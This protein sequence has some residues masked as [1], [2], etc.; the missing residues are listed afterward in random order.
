MDSCDRTTMPSHLG[1]D[2]DVVNRTVPN[3]TCYILKCPPEILKM[4]S[5]ALGHK[6][7]SRAAFSQTCRTIQAMIE[8]DIYRDDI[9][10]NRAS[11][12]FWATSSDNLA[13]LKKSVARGADIFN[14]GAGRSLLHDAAACGSNAVVKYLLDQ[15]VDIHKEADACMC[16][17]PCTL[18]GDGYGRVERP[19]MIP[20]KDTPK[21]KTALHVAICRRHPSTAKLLMDRGAL[22][23]PSD[24]LVLRQ[25][26]IR[27]A[28]SFGQHQLFDRILLGREADT[29]AIIAA[30]ER[31]EDEIVSH[32]TICDYG[33]LC[34]ALSYRGNI[35]T[36]DAL[37]KLG[38]DVNESP[39][40][41]ILGGF[42]ENLMDR[43]FS[44]DHLEM[45]NALFGHGARPENWNG[46]NGVTRLLRAIL[47]RVISA[48][49][50][51][52]TFD[53]EG[54]LHFI[55]HSSQLARSLVAAGANF[56]HEYTEVTE[57]MNTEWGDRNPRSPN[58]LILSALACSESDAAPLIITF[59]LEMGAT[60]GEVDNSGRT[61]LTVLIEA[62]G[63]D[64]W[65][66]YLDDPEEMLHARLADSS[67][68]LR[69]WE[70][71]RR[72]FA[73]VDV[74][75][76]HGASP[77]SPVRGFSG[78]TIIELV[79]DRF[80]LMKHS[81]EG[82]QAAR[83]GINAVKLVRLFLKHA[84]SSDLSFHTIAVL[85]TWTRDAVV[86]MRRKPPVTDLSVRG[87]KTFC[88]LPWYGLEELYETSDPSHDMWGQA[89]DA[90]S[91]DEALYIDTGINVYGNERGE[92]YYWY[93]DEDDYDDAD[94][95]E[96][97]GGDGNENEI[98]DEEEN[99][100]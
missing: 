23:S 96:S 45:T 73:A 54:T 13:A 28:A 58:G 25:I 57:G 3:Q 5:E 69:M 100:M 48:I 49:R 72:L 71:E 18:A 78:K 40:P 91:R 51:D 26:T 93:P 9:R 67:N 89:G 16:R 39:H 97:E 22:E 6:M 4:F 43:A 88:F 74:L 52:T 83:A 24:P 21:W 76:Q 99:L 59:L 8:E 37:V 41:G 35:E 60:V 80:P 15:G 63:N 46:V 14:P 68:Q 11:A 53:R 38:A 31:S 19:L 47:H 94:E 34:F 17:Q 1:V 12:M 90:G 2:A 70:K 30:T 42:G 77:M 92:D 95:D 62:F 81:Y 10:C 84:N 85:L 44:R 65:R 27:L 7:A 20:G 32:P 36:I 50:K 82:H 66:D 56:Y 79:L 75:L 55:K 98:Q 86:V 64:M 29:Q 33:A 87:D 61:A